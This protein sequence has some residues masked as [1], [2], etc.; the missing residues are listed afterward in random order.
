MLPYT[1]GTYVNFVDADIADWATAY[2]RSNLARLARVK[3]EYD[4]DDIF[5]GPQSIP[6]SAQ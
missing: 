4:P 6:L 5:G 2:Y 1:T 3:S